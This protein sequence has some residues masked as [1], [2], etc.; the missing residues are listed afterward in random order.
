MFSTVGTKALARLCD[1][2]KMVSEWG[3]KMRPRLVVTGASLPA[4]A[5]VASGSVDSK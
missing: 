1:H 4:V 5:T 2:V 3:A